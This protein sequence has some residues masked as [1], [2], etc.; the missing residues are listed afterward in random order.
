VSARPFHAAP[1]LAAAAVAVLAAC[2]HEAP[3]VPPRQVIAAS[4]SAL[5]TTEAGGAAS[6][7]VVLLARP[8]G[9][10]E[11]EVRSGDATEGLVL[12]PGY[13]VPAA[14][15]ELTFTPDDWDVPRRIVVHAMDDEVDDGDVAY[16]V[17]VRVAYSEDPADLSAAAVVVR[18]TNAD[19]DV[20][21][22][23]LSTHAL[24]TVERGAPQ[25]F[26]VR[27]GSMPSSAVYAVITSGDPLEGW[28]AAPGGCP[29]AGSTQWLWFDASSWDVA[30]DVAVC[31]QDDWAPD[32]D[33]TFAVTLEV[34]PHSAPEYA[35]L[36]DA[37]VTVTNADDETG[38]AVSA[39]ATPLV[40]SERGST[41]TFTVRLNAPPAADVTIPVASGN[42][43]EGLVASGGA[44]PAERI[45]LTFGPATWDAAQ[46]V[47]V[48]GQDDLDAPVALDDV[49]YAVTVGP[50]S[51]ADPA[52]SALAPRTVAVLNRDD[53][54]AAAFVVSRSGGTLVTDEGGATAAFLVAL[55]RP[56]LE[57]V[58]VY[59]TSGDA[60]E[61]LLKSGSAAGTSSSVVLGFTPLDWGKPRTV[62]VVGQPDLV[63]DGDQTYAIE[64]GPASSQ[65]AEFAAA[66]SRTLAVRNADVGIL[67][68]WDAALGAPRCA[69]ARIGCDSGTLLAGRGAFG[70]EP[71]APNTIGLA[72]ADGTDAPSSGSHSVDRI[73]VYG[74]GGSPLRAGGVALVEVFATG[75]GYPYDRLDLFHAADA[76]A[77]TWTTLVRD[78]PASYFTATFTLPGGGPLQAIRAQWRYGGS[79]GGWSPC[80]GG[81]FVDRDDLAFAVSP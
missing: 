30:Q 72:C 52:F 42:P 56:P 79:G 18:V 43:R 32:G 63:A 14:V 1:H 50:P 3:R 49:R 65:D 22:I 27:L 64:V 28:V 74:A 58:Q 36:P 70:P 80:E 46:I 81:S 12:A 17:A 60:S 54:V 4:E 5:A 33:R 7:D 71:N 13:A 75:L 16:D 48:V 6:F 34:Q 11:V 59:V 57:D 55:S 68:S 20:P 44:G 21:A 29:W 73:L 45:D 25:T 26:T 78:A 9:P 40:T 8:P 51:S 62:T 10:I 37:S 19:D 23:A 41:A 31:P 53:D 35:L 76:S 39:A 69:D 67:A 47:T 61:G 2:R 38:Y 24:V 77:P 15:R 66:P